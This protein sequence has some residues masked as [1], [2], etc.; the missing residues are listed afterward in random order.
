MNYRGRV[1]VHVHHVVGMGDFHA[2]GQGVQAVLL[3]NLQ[4]LL[5]PAYQNDVR[6]VTLYRF[7]G[8]EHR[9]LGGIVAAHRVQNNLHLS[10]SFFRCPLPSRPES[11]PEPGWKWRDF[12]LPFYEFSAPK[13]Q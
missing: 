5:T 6:V 13:E 11:R 4:N 2:L 7:D 8:A 1:V 3:Q 12:F 9:S 10:T